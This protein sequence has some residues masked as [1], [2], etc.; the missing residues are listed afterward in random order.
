VGL[1]KLAR[2][3]EVVSKRPQVQERMTETI[4]H[5]LENELDATEALRYAEQSVQLED[6]FENEITK[7]RALTAL[8]RAGDA[9]VVQ[10]R[11]LTMGTQ[12]QVYNFG[13]SLQRLGQQGAAIAIYRD[14]IARDPRSVYAHLEG[15]RVAVAARDYDAAIKEINLAAAVAPPGLKASIEGL[16]TQLQQRVD[17]NR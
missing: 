10:R 9:R 15:A 3:V 7:A 17:I 12:Q 11:A 6:R 5:L 4:A 16:R 1:S 2:V 13:R 14:D 8:G